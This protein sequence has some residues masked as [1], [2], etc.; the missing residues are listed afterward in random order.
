MT[1]LKTTLLTTMVLTA[2]LLPKAENET[3]GICTEGTGEWLLYKASVI[4]GMK[5][6]EITNDL[7]QEWL[8][9][10]LPYIANG[11][12]YTTEEVI[13]LYTNKGEK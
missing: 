4:N 5:E 7:V 9:Y 11:A 2:N 10:C 3:I 6:E 8:L 1:N 13:K 12:G